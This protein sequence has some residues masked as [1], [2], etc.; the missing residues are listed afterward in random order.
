MK[1]NINKALPEVITHLSGIFDKE[2]RESQNYQ[3]LK[4]ILEK[5][6]LKSALE[7][8]GLKQYELA[9]A[10]LVLLKDTGHSTTPATLPALMTVYQDQS[11]ARKQLGHQVDVRFMARDIM[12]KKVIDTFA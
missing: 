7:Y 6:G 11:D 8:L 9:S 4:G 10:M 3:D 12:H 5:E 2:K 1:E